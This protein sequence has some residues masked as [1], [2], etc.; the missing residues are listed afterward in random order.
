MEELGYEYTKQRL[1]Y[2][3]VLIFS[4]LIYNL[5]IAI[6]FLI[7]TFQ[8][9]NFSV[10]LNQDHGKFFC[11]YCMVAVK[12]DGI[13]KYNDISEIFLGNHVLSLLFNSEIVQ[14][15]CCGNIRRKKIKRLSLFA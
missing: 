2:T 7:Q 9:F 10:V 11:G 3:R 1:A 14:Q 6:Y 8:L 5:C 15:M 13:F 4:V 12:I